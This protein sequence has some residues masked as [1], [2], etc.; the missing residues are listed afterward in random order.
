MPARTRKRAKFDFGGRPFVWWVDADHWLR[1][2]SADK[3]FVVACPL[4]RHP[5][6]PPTMVVIGSEFVGLTPAE[7]RPV[8]LVVPEA[9]APS[10]GGWVHH[11]L[12]WSFDPEHDLIRRAGS[13]RFAWVGDHD[14]SDPASPPG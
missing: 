5:D 9:T 4:G 12:R 13:I 14:H 3:R 10:M 8:L 1:I 11:L 7:R 6:D 2:A